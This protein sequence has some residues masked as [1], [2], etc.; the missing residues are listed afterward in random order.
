MIHSKAFT[1][2]ASR[3]DKREFDVFSF[4]L[5]IFL[6]NEDYLEEKQS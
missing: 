4:F 3:G 2:V 1:G 6:K 5:V